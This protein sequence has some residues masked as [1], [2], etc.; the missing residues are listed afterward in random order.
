MPLRPAEQDG[1]L[2]VQFGTPS[3]GQEEG[4]STPVQLVHVPPW[5]LQLPVKAQEA[6]PRGRSR[7]AESAHRPLHPPS[8]AQ[9][10]SAWRPTPCRRVRRGGDRS[11]GRIRRR[12]HGLHDPQLPVIPPPAQREPP[13]EI[14]SRA[15]HS[16]FHEEEWDAGSGTS[17]VSLTLLPEPLT[18]RLT[19]ARAAGVSPGGEGLALRARKRGR[20]RESLAEPRHRVAH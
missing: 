14:T 15:A 20:H 5:L 19:A 18:N 13:N 7:R 3:G 17:R 10:P 2:A 11:G 4:A 6:P 8:R 1:R 16:G 9:P 12:G